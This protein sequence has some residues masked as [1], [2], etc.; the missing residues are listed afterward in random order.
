LIMAGL[1]LLALLAVWLLGRFAKPAYADL[2]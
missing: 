2:K 1:V